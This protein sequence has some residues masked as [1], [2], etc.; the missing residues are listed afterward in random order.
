MSKLFTD[1]QRDAFLDHMS[2]FTCENSLMWHCPGCLRWHD[3]NTTVSRTLCAIQ[4]YEN[5][6]VDPKGPVSPLIQVM[7]PDCGYTMLFNAAILAQTIPEIAESIG[8]K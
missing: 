5:A 6:S 2:L 3:Y 4:S 8:V 1:E 7:C